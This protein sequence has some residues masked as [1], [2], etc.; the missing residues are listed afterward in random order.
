M[1]LGEYTYDQYKSHWKDIRGHTCY[2]L[3][4]VG[5]TGSHVP[6]MREDEFDEAT[7]QLQQLL[8]D[9]EA[10]MEI[11]PDEL[12]MVCWEIIDVKI[13]LL[14]AGKSVRGG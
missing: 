9:E 2:W 4:G 3:S 12:E 14:L 7:A 8:R 10:A 13:P 5:Y 6:L 1:Q 11:G